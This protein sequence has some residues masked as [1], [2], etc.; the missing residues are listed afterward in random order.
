MAIYPRRRYTRVGRRPARRGRTALTTRPRYVRTRTTKSKADDQASVYVDPFSLRTS[1]PKIPDGKCRLSS[2]IRLQAVREFVNDTGSTMGFVIFPGLNNAVLATNTISD[3]L[4][5]FP[6]HGGFTYD[7][8]G[9]PPTYTQTDSNIAKWRQ[10]SLGAKFTLVNNS[11][12]NDGWFE[13][14]RFTSGRTDSHFQ[15]GQLSG[16]IGPIPEG[17][18]GTLPVLDPAYQMVEHPSYVTGKLR[19]IHRHLF[20]L[21]PHDTDHDFQHVKGVYEDDGGGRIQDMEH[22]LMD[23]S[24]DMI[25]VRI[26]GRVGDGGGGGTPTRVMLHIVSNQEIMY[27]PGTP[28]S[29]FHTETDMSSYIT[30]LK[31][32]QVESSQKATKRLKVVTS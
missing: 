21:K 11:D 18:G 12:E 14:V 16:I 24:Y 19:D 3:T 15:V 4:M 22:D 25:F 1:N 29:R 10:V 31:R 26:H 7:G 28:L 30:T 20:C 27:E 32:S 6:A 8:V 5:P 17:T 2:G 23:H 9:V 13:A